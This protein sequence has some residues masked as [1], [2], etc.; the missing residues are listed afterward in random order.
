MVTKTH[1]MKNT[2]QGI[3]GW[4]GYF[5]I[6]IM[7]SCGGTPEV[8]PALHKR[9]TASKVPEQVIVIRPLGRVDMKKVAVVKARLDK[10]FDSVVVR[11]P[12]QIPSRFYY[13]P[14]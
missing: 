7:L 2:L 5:S 11:R 12:E 3:P 10:I 14:R 9:N 8:K 4:I 1:T 6:V 13:R